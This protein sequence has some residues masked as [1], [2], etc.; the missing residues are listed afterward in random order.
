[1]THKVPKLKKP[2]RPTPSTKPSS[3]QHPKLYLLVLHKLLKQIMGI[4]KYI[5]GSN[6]PGNF[7]I[8]LTFLK[9]V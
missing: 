8:S 2:K 6:L 1:M 9:Q 4:E 5:L 7:I 3:S